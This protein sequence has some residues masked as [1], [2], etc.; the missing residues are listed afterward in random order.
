MM[1]KTRPS[2]SNFEKSNKNDFELLATHPFYQMN[3]K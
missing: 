1:N 2:I 3:A